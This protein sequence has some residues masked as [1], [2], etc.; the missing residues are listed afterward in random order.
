[1]LEFT[2]VFFTAI[3][4]HA[5]IVSPAAAAKLGWTMLALRGMYPITWALEGEHPQIRGPGSVCIFFVSMP[6][7]AISIYLLATSAA[8]LKGVDLLATMSEYD[9]G[10]SFGR[11]YGF[12]TIG[13]VVGY[14]AY[15]FVLLILTLGQPYFKKCFESAKGA[16]P[17]YDPNDKRTW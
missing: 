14:M 12:D 2:P 13:C 9:V 7:R 15:L 16:D 6:Q 11:S 4:A 17:R 1:M 8:T 10:R 5:M 3:W